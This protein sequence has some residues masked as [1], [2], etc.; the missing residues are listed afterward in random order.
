M[1]LMTK[2]VKHL[3]LVMDSFARPILHYSSQC[4]FVFMTSYHTLMVDYELIQE[5][6]DLKHNQISLCTNILNVYIRC[7]GFQ[8]LEIK[9]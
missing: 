1:H 9:K 2:F 7:L 3:K 6:L 5:G 8:T 4:S